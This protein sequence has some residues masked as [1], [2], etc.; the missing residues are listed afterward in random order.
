MVSK[1]NTD[2]HLAPITIHPLVP[3]A[4]ASAVL[5]IE[6]GLLA[7][8][9]LAGTIQGE[10]RSENGPQGK[11][12][13]TE[14]KIETTNW[15]I[16]AS[17]FEK[18]VNDQVTNYENRISTDGLEQLFQEREFTEVEI[19]QAKITAL[20]AEIEDLRSQIIREQL[21]HLENPIVTLW[22]RMS[23]LF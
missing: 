22:R 7:E 3:L 11:F 18:L 5:R 14:A 2:M 23:K 10:Q 17:E 1:R 8:Q 12:T 13:A 19:L 16:Y 20:S 6:P 15:F 4:K 9:L 21:H